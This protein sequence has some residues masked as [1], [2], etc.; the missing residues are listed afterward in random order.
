MKND[1]IVP[2]FVPHSVRALFGTRVHMHD[3]FHDIWTKNAS[4]EYMRRLFF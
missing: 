1:L 4:N 3:N 2:C